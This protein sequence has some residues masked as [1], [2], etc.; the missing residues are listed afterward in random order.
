M[1]LGRR[2]RRR[3][4]VPLDQTA[5]AASPREGRRRNFVKTTFREETMRRFNVHMVTEVDF[6]DGDEA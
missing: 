4:V 1:R 5:G 2:P 3:D 6:V